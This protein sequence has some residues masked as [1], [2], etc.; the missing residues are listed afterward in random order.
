MQL[1]SECASPGTSYTGPGSEET[2]K[3]GRYPDNPK[4]KCDE[5]AKQVTDVYLVQKASN[6]ERMQDFP[7]RRM[8]AMWPQ[9]CT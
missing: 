6:P 2:W 4:G 8:E 9:T 5:L 3:F 7:R 1:T